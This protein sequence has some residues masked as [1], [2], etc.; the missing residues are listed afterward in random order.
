MLIQCGECEREISSLSESCVGCGAP[1]QHSLVDKWRLSR[2]RASREGLF[3][4]TMNV[5]TALALIALALGFQS[6]LNALN[7]MAG[8]P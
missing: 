4:R 6:V 1:T 3:L 7:A 8:R 2:L 5:V